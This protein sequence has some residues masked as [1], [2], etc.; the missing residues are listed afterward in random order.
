MW[1]GMDSSF[2]ESELLLVLSSDRST[3][4]TPGCLAFLAALAF[5]RC[6]WSSSI[7][8]DGPD[9]LPEVLRPTG[10]A[11][12]TRLLPAV[13]AVASAAAASRSRRALARCFL[14]GRCCFFGASASALASPSA[15]CLRR[16]LSLRRL[17]AAVRTTGSL[18]RRLRLFHLKSSATNGCEAA[19]AMWRQRLALDSSPV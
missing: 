16:R 5:L 10:G 17:R 15:P 4:V 8:A 7:Q 2:G 19:R 9:P 6:A 12:C 14:F 13:A 1:R 18:A 3:G 11:L